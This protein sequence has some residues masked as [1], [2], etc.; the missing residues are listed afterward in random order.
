MQVL[1]LKSAAWRGLLAWIVGGA[2]ALCGALAYGGLAVR[3]PRSGGEYTFLAEAVHPAAGFLAGWVSFLAGFSAAIALAGLGLEVYLQSGLGV[4]VPDRWTATAVIVVAGALHGVQLRRGVVLQ[5]AI[6]LLKLAGIAGL[7][8]WGAISIPQHPSAPASPGAPPIGAFAVTLVWISLAYSGWN[9]AV[10]IAGEIRDPARNLPRALWIPTAVVTGIYLALNA[11]FLWGAPVS[12]LAGRPDVA[13][14]AAEHLGGT[15]LRRAV[16]GLVSI[17]LTTSVLSMTMAGSRVYA[18]MARDGL[19]PAGLAGGGDAPTWAVTLQV[20]V[21]LLVLWSSNLA[22]LLSYLG[23]TLGLSAAGT[24]AAGAC[25]RAREGPRAVPI[26]G[27]PWTPWVFV[28]ATLG[29]AVF[30]VLRE[31]RPAGLGLAT[32]LVG[33]IPYAWAR[34]RQGTKRRGRSNP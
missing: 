4:A 33:L 12:E 18:Q 27:Y 24:V 11:V 1:E 5:N 25:L 15:G 34:R 17:A 21:A 3:I 9:G 23:F 6:V 32:A 28:F 30:M 7:I 8:G 16:A 19:A 22:E 10:Y 14:V 26:I 2:I 13:A 31:P 29:G 20:T